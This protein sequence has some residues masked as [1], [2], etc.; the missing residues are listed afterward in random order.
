MI[1]KSFLNYEFMLILYFE[2]YSLKCE[3]EYYKLT[4]LLIESLGIGQ[5]TSFKI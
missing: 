1:I 5:N 4:F 2:F 3:W